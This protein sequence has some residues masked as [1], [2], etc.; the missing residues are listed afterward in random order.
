MAKRRKSAGRRTRRVGAGS[1]YAKPT[2]SRVASLSE[3]RQH[4]SVQGSVWTL[5]GFTVI[6]FV[7]AL[8]VALVSPALEKAAPDADLDGV[9][10]ARDICPDTVRGQI[11]DGRGC[12][13][14]QVRVREGLG[15]DV[16]ETRF[17]LP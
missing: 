1:A 14:E 10:D 5:I 15:M 7:I 8:G 6:L 2:P 13:F 9:L 3:V 17:N 11:L 16:F 12:S 4:E